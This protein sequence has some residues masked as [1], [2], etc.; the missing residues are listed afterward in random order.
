MPGR[1]IYLL[2]AAMAI[3]TIFAATSC[4]PA[5]LQ[6]LQ[7]KLQNIDSVSGNVTVKLKD[8]SLSTFNFKDITME[9]IGKSIG[10]TSLNIG[11]NVTIRAYKNNKM[12]HPET[13]AAE[14]AGIIKSLGTDNVT[15]TVD[16]K[17]DITLKVTAQTQIKF[18]GKNKPVFADLKVGQK[19]DAKYE[20]SSNKALTIEINTVKDTVKSGGKNEQNNNKH[21]NDDGKNGENE[22]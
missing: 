3:S 21:G 12:P 15:I 5:E 14:V 8:G 19:V 22:D 17:G 1:K 13:H 4:T 9:T 18:D 6:A 7:G 10:D 2:V 11:D 20:L 16:K